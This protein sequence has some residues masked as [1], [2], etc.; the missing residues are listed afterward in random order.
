MAKVKNFVTIIAQSC[1]KWQTISWP[2][3]HLGLI[4]KQKIWVFFIIFRSKW[5][6]FSGQKLDKTPMRIIWLSILTLANR[7][8][9]TLSIDVKKKAVKAILVIDSI[10]L[11]PSWPLCLSGGKVQK[12]SD[13]NKFLIC[14]LGIRRT[15][16]MRDQ[17]ARQN[18]NQ[19]NHQ[20]AAGN[21]QTQPRAQWGLFEK[22]I[23]K[24]SHK[25]TC[26]AKSWV[27]VHFVRAVN[28]DV[29]LLYAG[30]VWMLVNI[31]WVMEFILWG[32][33]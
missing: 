5:L 31:S 16:T 26:V 17:R 25:K 30:P 7:P 20:S 21:L 11:N 10:I 12:W 28:C 6:Y 1:E 19:T 22:Y 2:M 15:H 4:R 3:G 33:T 18:Q 24:R 9:D 29:P 32:L 23:K 8:S 14:F 27:V 13:F